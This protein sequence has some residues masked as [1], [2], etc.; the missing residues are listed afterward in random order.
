MIHCAAC[1]R[2]ARCTDDDACARRIPLMQRIREQ[3]ATEPVPIRGPEP[4]PV[5]VPEPVESIVT[6]PD[7]KPP[8]PINEPKGPMSTLQQTE[9]RVWWAAIIVA[10]LEAAALALGF[11]GVEVAPVV[12]AVVAGQWF[13]ALGLVLAILTAFFHRVLARAIRGQS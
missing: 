10:A 8:A 1:D 5:D 13:H 12:D 7:I 6:V 11:V 3:K 2:H 4:L 9:N